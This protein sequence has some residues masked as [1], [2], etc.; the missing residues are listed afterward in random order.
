MKKMLSKGTARLIFK[1]LFLKKYRGKRLYVNFP[2]CFKIDS[3]CHFLMLQT[4]LIIELA[5]VS[6]LN[7]A[8]IYACVSQFILPT[9]FVCITNAIG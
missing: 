3:I 6:T 5:Q 7:I 2:E 9:I 4:T 1:S 8:L